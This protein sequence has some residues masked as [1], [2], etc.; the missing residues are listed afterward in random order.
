MVWVDITV[1][2]DSPWPII[3]KGVQKV[4]S[5]FASREGTLSCAARSPPG[6]AVVG[7]KLG[8]KSA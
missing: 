5:G 1:H 2:N 6:R 7:P 8:L 4:E 3:E